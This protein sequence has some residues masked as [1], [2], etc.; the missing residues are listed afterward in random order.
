MI[1]SYCP[2]ILT[3]EQ[4]MNSAEYKHL[5]ESFTGYNV[6]LRRNP[7]TDPSPTDTISV[8]NSGFSTY[9]QIHVHCIETFTWYSTKGEAHYLYIIPEQDRLGHFSLDHTLYEWQWNYLDA[10]NP[11]LPVEM[12]ITTTDG[13]SKKYSATDD[14]SSIIATTKSIKFYANPTEIPA[15]FQL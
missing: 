3:L 8:T 11:N 15:Y 13:I 1:N 12:V 2:P 10:T 6:A 14:L 5:V 7:Y 9:K 4:I